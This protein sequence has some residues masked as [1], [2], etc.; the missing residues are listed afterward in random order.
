MPSQILKIFYNLAS[1]SINKLKK[2]EFDKMPSQN[3]ANL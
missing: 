2:K 3:I 1:Q